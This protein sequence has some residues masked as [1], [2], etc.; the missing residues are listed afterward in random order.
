MAVRAELK[1]LLQQGRR[2]VERGESGTPLTQGKVRR[3]GV[4]M[5]PKDAFQGHERLGLTE[6][7]EVV[8]RKENFR[9]Q[10]FKNRA[11]PVGDEV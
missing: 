9:V 4:P 6:G 3:R 5:R 10:D 11:T 1:W 2:G 7:S 8:V